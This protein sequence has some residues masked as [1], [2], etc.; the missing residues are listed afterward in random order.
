ASRCIERSENEL[1]LRWP[2]SRP[3]PLRR[4]EG[5][6]ILRFG[7]EFQTTA[8]TLPWRGRVG[9]ASSE[10]RCEPGWGDPS[11]RRL[12]ETKNC[13]PT[14]PLI[15]FAATLPLQGRVKRVHAAQHSRGE[16]RPSFCKS[17]VPLDERAQGM[18]GAGR[19]RS[20]VC[21]NKVANEHSHHRLAE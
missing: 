13:H 9:E 3:K 16:I 15:S 6:A 5:P 18:P 8:P 20:L 11:T 17:R 1:V 21:K 14:P 12:S 19:T 7:F 4:G 2:G 10:A